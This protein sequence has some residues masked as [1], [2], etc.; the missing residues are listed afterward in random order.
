MNDNFS[1]AGHLNDGEL[2]VYLSRFAEYVILKCEGV[3]DPNTAAYLSAQ[4]FLTEGA[5]AYPR[6]TS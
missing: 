5:R 1:D 4:W 6:R 2:L 3:A